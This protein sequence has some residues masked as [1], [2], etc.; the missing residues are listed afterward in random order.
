MSDAHLE[1][2]CE[3]GLP[4]WL[5]DIAAEIGVDAAL[6]V[7]RLISAAARERGDNR[8]HVPAWSTYLRYQRNR[9]IRSLDEQGYPP[10]EIHRQVQ[11]V[12]CERISLA[13]VKRII[14]RR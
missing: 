10:D 14:A 7:W 8:L 11:T 3:I 9:F 12:L 2:L 4:R 6:S 13:H 1:E 5:I